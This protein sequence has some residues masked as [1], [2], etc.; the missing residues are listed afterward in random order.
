MEDI[1]EQSLTQLLDIPSRRLRE[2]VKEGVITGPDDYGMYSVM[3][4][5]E[6]VRWLKQY[7]NGIE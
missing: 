5:R 2:L 1:G 7:T 4:I 6:Y 3:A